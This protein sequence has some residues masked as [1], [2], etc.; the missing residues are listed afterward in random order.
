MPTAP[1]KRNYDGG[2]AAAMMLKDLKRAQD[3]A[4]KVGASA[5]LGPQTEALFQMFNGLGYGGRDFS[6][7]LQMLRGQLDDLP[8]G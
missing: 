6:A 2:F 8:K 7:I 4:A 5:P 3:T 1:S